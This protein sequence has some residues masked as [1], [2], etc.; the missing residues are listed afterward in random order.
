MPVNIGNNLEIN[1]NEINASQDD[2]F[3]KLN[4]A[5]GWTHTQTTSSGGTVVILKDDDILTTVEC[6]DINLCCHPITKYSSSESY[7]SNTAFIINGKI[8]FLINNEL[9]QMGS[10]TNYIKI[11]EN[12]GGSNVYGID[13][14][15]KLWYISSNT[16]TQIG[17]STTW[18]NFMCNLLYDNTI[19]ATNDGKLYILNGTG[20]PTQ[21]CTTLNNVLMSM[22]YRNSNN[23]TLYGSV[24]NDTDIYK[25][26]PNSMEIYGS[27][28]TWRY[29]NN[30]T[31]NFFITAITTDDDLYSNI[32]VDGTTTNLCFVCS[33]VKIAFS[34]GG[35]NGILLLTN[36][37]DI[38]IKNRSS[39]N[40]NI[41]NGIKWKEI[42]SPTMYGSYACKFYSLS[43]DGK[44]YSVITNL[45]QNTVTYTQIGTDANYKK[46]EGRNYTSGNYYALAW[47]GDATTVSHTV[48]TTKSPQSNDA[49]YIDEDLN[50][51]ST[52]Q[53]TGGTTVT[54][55]YRTYNRDASKDTSFTAI[56]PATMHETVSTIDFLRI[57]NPNT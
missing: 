51:Y 34:V 3:K 32:Y 50:Q 1:N 48:L 35:G 29:I 5:Y 36:D 12:Q 47:T 28:H 2:L 7:L 31:T 10:K 44:I 46:I 18:E 53:S 30:N 11:S 22:I 17:T 41:S 54:D 23:N 20:T 56:P 38:Y 26:T 13:S 33:N 55:Q 25:L 15:N 14:D 52:I 16:E 39:S 57:T 6:D 45:S 37:G 40:Y 24:L 49:A 9:V 43:E 27:E 8:Y 19:Y 4:V 21:I 42:T